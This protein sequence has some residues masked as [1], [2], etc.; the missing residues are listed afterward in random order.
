MNDE[1]GVF[2][3]NAAWDEHVAAHEAEV[4]R[5]RTTADAARE[6]LR[7]LAEMASNCPCGAYLDALDNRPHVIGCPVAAALSE[8][9][10]Q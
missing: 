10:P 5:L 3:T 4:G 7:T 8:E 1:A 9:P 6:A 2:F